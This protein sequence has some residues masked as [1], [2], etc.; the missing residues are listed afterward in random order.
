M[1]RQHR[2]KNRELLDQHSRNLRAAPQQP[3]SFIDFIPRLGMTPAALKF[4]DNRI[5]V[6]QQFLE[7]QLVRLMDDDEQQFVVLLRR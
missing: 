5:Q 4:A 1:R 2:L 3:R 7:P 6:V